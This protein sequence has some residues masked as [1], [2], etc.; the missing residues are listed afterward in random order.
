MK[1]HIPEY[2]EF[3]MPTKI[4]AGENALD[5]LPYEL[6][7]I[8]SSRPMVVTDCGVKG[9]GL[10]KL[11]TDVL[12]GAGTEPCAI[13][14]ETPPDSSLETVNKAADIYI[15]NSCD[16]IIALGGGSVI[17]TAKG[18]NMLV[19][20]G[21]K[22]IAQYMGADLLDKKL[23]PL[24]VLPTTSGTGSEVTRVAVISDLEAHVKMPF[25]SQ[26]LMPDVALL[27]P[28]L[29]LSLPPLHTAASGMDALTH[30]VESV[31][32][33]QQN[34]ISTGL[35]YTAISIVR[36]NLE[37]AVSGGDRDVRLAMAN[38]SCLAGAAFS[39]A[40]VG[41]VHALGHASGGVAHI[42][43]GVAMSIL[44][45]V[46]LRYNMKAREAEMADLLLPMGG[47]QVYAETR[48]EDRAE[49]TIA[50]ITELQKRLHGLCGLPY[51]LEEAGVKR[52]QLE[53]IA[54]TAI[55]DG[56]AMYNPVEIELNDAL[57]LLEEAFRRQA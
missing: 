12:S 21:G 51:S 43:H 37:S 10:L 18:V 5:Q 57:S 7:L 48:P 9:A 27:D 13:Y 44:L 49:K 19:S 32:S 14:D 29:T 33:L 17:D 56:S 8:N 1:V 50:L 40:M 11:L 36:D 53:D 42:P 4:L 22:D 6:N 38:A 52:E 2:Y 16:S 20:T 46:G 26:M 54:R 3:S 45:P 24:I 47:S 28:R 25:V 34:P 55:N 15:N 30:A 31:I 39:N 35:A 41:V 23:S